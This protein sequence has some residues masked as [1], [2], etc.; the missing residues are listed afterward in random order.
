MFLEKLLTR[1]LQP[2]HEFGMNGFTDTPFCALFGVAEFMLM[3]FLQTCFNA[4][5]LV[6]LI[7]VFERGD[8]GFQ[9]G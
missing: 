7:G 3:Y 4:P 5:E 6:Q 9:T 2:Q 1:F 8:A